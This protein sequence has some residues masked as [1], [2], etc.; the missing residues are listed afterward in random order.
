VAEEDEPL[1]A[2]LKSKRRELA[3]AMR[4]PAYVV[5]PDRTLI[6]MV[7][8]MPATLDEFAQLPGVGAKKLEKFGKT[9]LAVING[10]SGTDLHP[11]RLKLA[12]REGGGLYDR[13][14]AAQVDLARGDDGAGKPMSCSATMLAKLAAQ[15]PGDQDGLSRILG[16]GKAERFGARFLE[17]LNGE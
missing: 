4:A 11:A 15:R 10:S 16:E 7:A 12:G 1:L 9:F 17:I 5:F 8:A 14:L 13:L 3:E 6:E 2:A